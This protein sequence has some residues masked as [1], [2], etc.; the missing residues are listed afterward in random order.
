MYSDTGWFAVPFVIGDILL[1]S[2]I[3]CIGAVALN[4]DANLF[5]ADD[6]VGA[7]GVSL[8]TAGAVGVSLVIAGAVWGGDAVDSVDSVAAAWFVCGAAG[9]LGA[10]WFVVGTG[11]WLAAAVAGCGGWAAAVWLVKVFATWLRIAAAETGGGW[12]SCCWKHWN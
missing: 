6:I 4:R 8:V 5:V 3:G 11:E 7:V 2:A 12:G 9:W 10:V 1:A